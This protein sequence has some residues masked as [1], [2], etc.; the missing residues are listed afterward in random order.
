MAKIMEN[1]RKDHS[2][3]LLLLDILGNQ[4]EPLRADETPDYA[5][6]TE[7]LS[8]CLTYPDL[9]HH[10]MEDRIYN[11]L[12]ES[13]AS[14]EQTGDMVTAHE[15]LGGMTRRL[16]DMLDAARL[17]KTVNKTVL[18]SLAESFVESYKRHI[19]AEEKVFFPLAEA[20]LAAAD[21]DS[22]DSELSRM[23][24]PLFAENARRDYPILSHALLDAMEHT[25]ERRGRAR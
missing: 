9:Y 14:P 12:V 22:I 4:I 17:G 3:M 20:Q 11:R 19:D 10:P 13:G 25:I 5:V 18:A 7:I 16:H 2:N 6:L 21:W 8:Y 1:L 23:S 24:D 15:E